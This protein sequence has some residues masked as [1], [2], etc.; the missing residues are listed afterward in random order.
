MIQDT[1]AELEARLHK[2]EAVNPESRAELLRLIALLK[3]ELRERG[4][5]QASSPQTHL[6]SEEDREKRRAEL[7]M[8]SLD[9]LSDSVTRFEETHPQ[10]VQV[11]NRICQTL[12]NLGI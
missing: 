8:L 9:E 4:E 11:V 6:I 1:I 7:S 12:A 5:T 3:H 2:A 10:L